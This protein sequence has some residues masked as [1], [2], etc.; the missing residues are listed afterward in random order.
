MPFYIQNIHSLTT[1]SWDHFE[2]KSSNEHGSDL[3]QFVKKI[4]MSNSAT[5]AA[6]AAATTTTTTTTTTTNNNNVT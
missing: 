3:Q 2:L 5:A 1:S 4:K 6:A